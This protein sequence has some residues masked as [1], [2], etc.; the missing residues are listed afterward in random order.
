MILLPNG[1]PV[2]GLDPQTLADL[3][4]VRQLKIIEKLQRQKRIGILDRLGNSRHDPAA[5]LVLKRLEHTRTAD[6]KK[7]AVGSLGTLDDLL[8]RMTENDVLG[9]IRNLRAAKH[10][11]LT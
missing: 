8:S 4:A 5:N 9:Q 11:R 10:D 6:D 7:V 2:K 3:A 1:P